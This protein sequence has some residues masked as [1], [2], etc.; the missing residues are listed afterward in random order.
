MPKQ[1]DPFFHRRVDG[2]IN[3][4]VSASLSGE[5]PER[6]ET[7]LVRD[8]HT[9]YGPDQQ[10]FHHA[11]QRV[12]DRLVKQQRAQYEGRSTASSSLFL[13]EK[14]QPSQTWQVLQGGKRQMNENKRSKTSRWGQRFGLLVAILITTVM[15]GSLLL[16]LNSVHSSSKTAHGNLATTNSAS[17][18]ATQIG[19][20]VFRSQSQP[21]GVVNATWSPDG[22]RL[23][24]SSSG[25]A[26]IQDA[27]TG[28]NALTV[29]LPGGDLASKALA[30]SPDGKYLATGETQI[31]I[32][33]TTNGKVVRSWPQ[34]VSWA[35]SGSRT[36]LGARVPLGGLGGP[37][38]ATAWSPDGSLMATALSGA[39]VGSSVVVWN[40]ATGEKIFTFQGQANN[41]AVVAVSWSPDGT[42]VA[43]ASLHSVQVWNA[44]TGQVIFKKTGGQVA[45]WAPQGNVL[46]F[47][48]D[49]SVEVWDPI[50]NKKITSMSSRNSFALAW[51]PDGTKIVSNDV[52]ISGS[53]AIIWS[54]TTGKKL[55][56]FVNP[57]GNSINSLAWSP[58][59][60]FIASGDGYNRNNYAEIWTAL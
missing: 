32:I 13:H 23:A 55:F 6:P 28:K 3:D 9:F 56:T 47:A 40:P 54:A 10:R 58:D 24:F 12:E 31:H 30:W 53:N 60:R 29:T 15:V 5:Q 38:Q 27:M 26:I 18:T 25:T 4:V 43:S 39:G 59:G 57:D 42:Y 46:A 52:S 21:D 14:E 50:A 2:F 34:T 22:Q 51:S 20:V 17:S 7:D 33:D 41:D 37:V 8:L 44:H 1:K 19:Q 35:G 49:K 36:A 16:V 11:L 45:A 48:T